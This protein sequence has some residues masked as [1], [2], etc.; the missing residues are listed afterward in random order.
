MYRIE[1]ASGGGAEPPGMVMQLVSPTWPYTSQR[2]YEVVIQAPGRPVR[3]LSA[4][5]LATTRLQT[6][7]NPLRLA[8]GRCK[9]MTN[10][11][12]VPVT[13]PAG[14]IT[15]HHFRDTEGDLELWIDPTA[16]F[17]LVQATG[18]NSGDVVL[19]GRG[20]G[21]ESQITGEPAER[22]RRGRRGPD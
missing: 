15:A 16:P 14:T 13:V 21:A 20:T 18:R 7:P 17:G 9:Q 3:R 10:L 2:L 4:Q 5:Q 22:G 11:G 8:A 12:E 6:P 19:I 1:I